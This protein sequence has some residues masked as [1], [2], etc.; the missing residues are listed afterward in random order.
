MLKEV[1]KKHK[2]AHEKARQILTDMGFKIEKDF[3]V[4]NKPWDFIAKKHGQTYYIDSKSPFSAK[5]A[6]FS[7]SRSE[8]E[9][10][11]DLRS[12]GIP[13][14]LFILPDGR[15]IFFVAV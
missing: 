11:M 6:T 9:G 14:Y 7:I 10:M 15:N 5:K 2:I 3:V 1:R 8:I 4:S 13:A 12:T